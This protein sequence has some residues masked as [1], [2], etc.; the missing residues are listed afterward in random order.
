MTKLYDIDQAFEEIEN[1]LIQSMKRNM[2][3]HL[4]DE[5]IEGINWEMWQMEMLK[6]LSDYSIENKKMLNNSFNV[7][8]KEL[9]NILTNTYN[10]TG[11]D[12]EKEILGLLASNKIKSKIP[13]K[14]LDILDKING[15]SYQIKAKT[16]LD[17]KTL[18][19][20]FFKLNNT[21]L[22]VLIKASMGEIYRSE[23][24]ILRKTEDIYR[25]IIFKSQVYANT[26]AGTIYQAVDMASRDFLTA[27]ITYV[28]LK[29]GNQLNIKSY[30]EM[31]IRTANK[32]ASLVAAG[33]VRSDWGIHTVI[34]S[35]YG[36]CSPICLPWQGKIYIDD[37]YSNGSKFD[38]SYPLLSEAIAG[39]LF[40][41][42]CR[43][44]SNTYYEGI[45]SKPNVFKDDKEI[46]DN[47]QLEQQQRY[48]ERQIR[49]Y[50]RLSQGSLDVKDID[51]YNR[52]KKDWQ[53]I[54]NKFIKDNDILRR[55]RWREI[56]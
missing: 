40:H 35:S 8:N 32:R 6:G 52:K 23:S 21:K 41:P 2:L 27:G 49:K 22:N 51:K 36:S 50:D 9:V 20:D 19:L 28:K 18:S 5:K 39:G 46:S 47:Y 31:A 4:K 34:V 42:N 37:I 29:N 25:Q 56:P 44:T 16:L 38:K 53:K 15:I 10:K 48:N 3:K 12:Q 17:S 54:N 30:S 33:D 11:L 26:G 14:I 7:L 55:D 1:N 24:S 13:K 43:H 45:S